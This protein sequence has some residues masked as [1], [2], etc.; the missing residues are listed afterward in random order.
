V[1]DIITEVQDPAREFVVNALSGFILEES[2]VWGD[3]DGPT[4]AEPCTVLFFT[5]TGSPAT[6][7][8]DQIGVDSAQLTGIREASIDIRVFAGG[9]SMA[10]GYRLE[11][12]ANI[13]EMTAPATDAGV[14][15]YD[16]DSPRDLSYV[17]DGKQRNAAGIAFSIRW[18][19]SETFDRASIESVT[20]TGNM[21]SDSGQT[22]T[23]D[24][25]V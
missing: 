17:K 6:D 10:L 9:D 20:I 13:D 14:F 2:I 23:A 1:R 7:S 19:E 12:A 21:T 5:P 22:Y 8:V 3:K 16:T 24:I 15:I 11:A 4:P 25:K 18:N